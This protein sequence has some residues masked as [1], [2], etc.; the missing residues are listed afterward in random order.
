[1]N[2]NTSFLQNP[3]AYTY[4]T[5]DFLRYSPTQRPLYSSSGHVTCGCLGRCVF[6]AG[7]FRSSSGAEFDPHAD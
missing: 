1:M 2:N 7:V 4:P 3:P 6:D 5:E